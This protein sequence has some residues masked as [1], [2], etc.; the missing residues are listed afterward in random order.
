MLRRGVNVDCGPLSGVRVAVVPRVVEVLALSLVLLI[1]LILC[2]HTVNTPY[3]AVHQHICYN[4]LLSQPNRMNHKTL[5]DA[6][7][8]NITPRACEFDCVWPRTQ[9]R[10]GTRWRPWLLCTCRTGRTSGVTSL[11]TPRF[12]RALAKALKKAKA[13]R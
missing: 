8:I 1:V 6:T 10:C 11:R 7:H 4:W 5:N 13:R 9:R 2:E 3:K 12:R